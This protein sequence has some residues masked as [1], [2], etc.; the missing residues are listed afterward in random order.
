MSKLIH[1][2]HIFYLTVNGGNKI[3]RQIKAKY[4]GNMLEARLKWKEH[5]KIKR[6]EL[7]LTDSII[8]CW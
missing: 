5:I 4:L 6:R 1:Q 2:Q 8:G 7:G 3:P